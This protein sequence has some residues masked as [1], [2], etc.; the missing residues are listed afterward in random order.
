[1]T[2]LMKVKKPLDR[3]RLRP[4][5]GKRTLLSLAALSLLMT[6]CRRD[7]VTHAR[8][9]KEQPLSPMAPASMSATSGDVPPPPAPG[10][11]ESLQWK[12]PK[13]WQETK[14][15]GMRFATLK[16]PVNGKLDVS[17][18]VLPGTAGGELANVNRWRGQIGL[19]PV[20]DMA[21]ASARK[22]V[23]SR[24]GTI[25]VYDFTSEGQARTRMIAGLMV[26]NGNSWFLKMVGDA[27]AVA[28]ARGGFLQLLETL[29]LE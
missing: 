10:G 16:P 12:L 25:S 20:D 19:P 15:G 24:A 1:M 23:K 2:S 13:G 7:E 22:A 5:W 11:G 8:V 28:S 21:L 18:V 17:V 3:Y 4:A 27:D 6:A 29:H 14:A 26:V 9:K